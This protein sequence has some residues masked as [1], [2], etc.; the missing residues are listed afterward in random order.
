MQRKSAYLA[1]CGNQNIRP[2]DESTL[3]SCA[4]QNMKLLGEE[5][6]KY[7]GYCNRYSIYQFYLSTIF[8]TISGEWEIVEWFTLN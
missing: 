1:F 2:N 5:T 8:S 7:C 4:A 6:F 3:I